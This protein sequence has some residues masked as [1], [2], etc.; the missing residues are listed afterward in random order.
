MERNGNLVAVI[1]GALIA[2]LL[3]LIVAP[4]IVILGAIPDF[5]MVYVLVVALTTRSEA[6][7][8]AFVM[9]LLYNIVGGGPVGSM[10]F[11]LIIAAYV[12]CKVFSLLD[13]DTAFIPLFIMVVCIFAIEILYGAFLLGIGFEANPVQAM[14]FRAIPCALYDCV[15]GFIMYP[16]ATRFLVHQERTPGMAQLR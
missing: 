4:Y 10:A 8:L 14:V 2:F 6:T 3:Q 9:G 15:I 13:N 11:L 16:L 7:I 5:M 12:A 1:I